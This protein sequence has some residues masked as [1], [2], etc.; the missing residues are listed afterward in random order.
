VRQSSDPYKRAVFCVLAACDP[1]EE[2]AEI[3]T[4]LDDYLWLKLCQV[5]TNTSVAFIPNFRIRD[6]LVRI[7]IL[8]SVPLTKGSGSVPKSS[9]TFRLKKNLFFNIFNV[10]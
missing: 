7:R 4:S 3:A 1:Q 6:I 2:H 8:G 10:L 5:P 9:V